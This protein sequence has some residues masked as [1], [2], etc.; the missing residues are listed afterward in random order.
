M[1]FSISGNLF[2]GIGIASIGALI[3]SPDTLFMRWSEM[4]VWSMLTWRGLEMGIILILFSSCFKIYRSK[5]KNIYSPVGLSIIISQIISS[6]LFTYGIAET[7]VSLILFCLATSPI[8]ASL[9]SI[10]ILGEKT[11]RATWITAF[12]ALVG[13]GIAVLNGDDVINAPQGSVLIGTICGIGASATLGLSLVLLRFKPNVPAMTVTGVSALGNGFIGL[14]FVEPNLL[15]Q[16]DILSISFSGLVILPISFACLTFATRYTPASN[17]G[18]LMLLE[19]ALGPFWVWVGTTETPNL[20][21]I[22]GGVI[23]IS[24]LA[25]YILI[26]QIK[27]SIT[28]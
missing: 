28:K 9:F 23:V 2:K 18:L 20:F 17:I 14:L 3:L 25:W 22:L 26:D 5:Y 21:M 12:F 24:S 27:F 16:G 7:S 8:F 13:V 11:N 15:F 1:N 6:L 10:F 4:D 19:T